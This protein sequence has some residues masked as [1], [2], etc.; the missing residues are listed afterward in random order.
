MQLRTIGL[1]LFVAG[2]VLAPALVE[3]QGHSYDANARTY[4]RTAQMLMQIPERPNVQLALKPGDDELDAAV[5]EIDRAGVVD[6]KDVVDRPAVKGN[7]EDVDR[8]ASIVE[9]LRAAR[10]EIQQDADNPHAEWRSVVVKHID[11]ALESVHKAAIDA[12]LDRQ[13][14][15]F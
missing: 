13:I 4:L 1:T 10:T 12:R 15:D 8:F 5:R 9:L 11:A 3:A 7:M 6:R 14:G 2:T